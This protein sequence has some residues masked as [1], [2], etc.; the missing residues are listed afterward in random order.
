[1]ADNLRK[2]PR[3]SYCELDSIEGL[4][5]DSEGYIF[6]SFEDSKKTK[7]QSIKAKKDDEDWG[8]GKHLAAKD[9]LRKQKRKAG[10]S[11]FE[12]IN[13]EIMER[14]R[15]KI[16]DPSLEINPLNESCPFIPYEHVLEKINN[17]KELFHRCNCFNTLM[18]EYIPTSPHKLQYFGIN[19][20]ESLFDE[21]QLSK[22]S[23]EELEQAASE[24]EE[25]L[26]ALSN[27][28]VDVCY[29]VSPFDENL[30]NSIAIKA[31]VL[32]FDWKGLGSQYQFDV[33][34]MDPP[35]RIQSSQMTRGVELG[36]E[37]LTDEEIMSMPLHLVQSNGF[38][39]MWVVASEYSN[40]LK[41]LEN[42]GYQPI[43]GVSWV[44]TSRRGI[45]HPSNGYYLQHTKESLLVGVKGKGANYMRSNEF[46]DLI[47]Q[48]RN[49]RQSHK[50]TK[51]YKIIENMF[52]GGMFLE[53][54]ARPHNLREN[55]ISLGLE[56]PSQ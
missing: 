30:K 27:I 8:A 43:N 36:Y 44:K 38:L 54:F 47:V 19:K 50:P 5:S 56:L 52:P 34:L 11:L 28:D 49:L 35:W 10:E 26:Q 6:S 1:M 31:N 22:M 14:N 2:K 41:M 51:L 17:P 13:Y 33:I 24:I 12:D 15:K 4:S 9:A 18:P 25:Q 32:N 21:H 45:Y 29:L 7:K 48:P 39:F 40:G 37:Q 53:V 55:W 20:E 23:E 3:V 42:W 16:N 46:T